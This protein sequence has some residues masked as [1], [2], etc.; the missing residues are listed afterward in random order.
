MMG[1]PQLNLEQAQNEIDA[2]QR[3]LTEYQAENERLRVALQD[4]ER[5]MR[6]KPAAG[7]EHRRCIDQAQQALSPPCYVEA[8]SKSTLNALEECRTE[9]D[10]LRDGAKKIAEALRSIDAE[11]ALLL[12]RDEA[13]MECEDVR[14]MCGAVLAKARELGLLEDK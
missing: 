8:D 2:L 7:D 9:R 3:R 10:K 14:D 11:A 6:F 12:E 4:C 13:E 1:H 5:W